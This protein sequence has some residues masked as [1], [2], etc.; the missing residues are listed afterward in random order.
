[1]LAFLAVI[2]VLYYLC[3]S[4][5]AALCC[6]TTRV[7]VY[8][9]FAST[10]YSVYQVFVTWCTSYFVNWGVQLAD[11]CD[12]SLMVVVDR[13]VV[14]V[15]YQ[16]SEV[17]L[18]EDYPLWDLPNSRSLDFLQVAFLWRSSSQSFWPDFDEVPA[19]R[20]TAPQRPTLWGY[21]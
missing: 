11:V 21:V 16:L 7:F 2:D 4:C 6:T 13:A 19:P 18:L 15:S 14:V 20:R 1:M 10:W 5:S 12:R 3:T 17:G 9:Y 8:S